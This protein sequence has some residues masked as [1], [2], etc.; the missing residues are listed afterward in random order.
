MSIHASATADVSSWEE[1][2]YDET[3]GQPRLA[4]TVVGN[5]YRGDLTG[6]GS[7]RSLMIYTSDESAE[8][9]GLERIVGRIGARSGSFV[10]RTGG[11]F[12]DNTATYEWS[13]VPGS[14]TGELSGL[15]GIGKVVWAHGQSGSLDFDYELD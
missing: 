6:N 8:F 10:V 3:E 2:N 9:T 5:T 15:R 14:G 1:H 13:I 7:A 12:E 11:I 4:S